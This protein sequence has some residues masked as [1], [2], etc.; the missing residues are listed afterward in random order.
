MGGRPFNSCGCCPQK[1]LFKQATLVQLTLQ[2]TNVQREHGPVHQEMGVH[3]Q[4]LMCKN[5]LQKHIVA[6]CLFQLPQHIK[7]RW[8]F[9]AYNYGNS[10]HKILCLL[11]NCPEKEV[12]DLDLI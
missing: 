1:Q 6:Q 2:Q 10:M 5:S 11:H 8:S 9:A 3:V 4:A 12:I 7:T